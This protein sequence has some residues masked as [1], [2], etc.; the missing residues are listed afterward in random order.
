MRPLRSADITLF[1]EDGANLR[2]AGANGLTQRLLE[3]AIQELRKELPFA[4]S[5]V[6]VGVGA[7][8]DVQVRSKFARADNYRAF[9]LRDRDFLRRALVEKNRTQVFHRKPDQVLPWPLPRHCI[10]SYLLDTDVLGAVAPKIDVAVIRSA[11]DQAASARKWND[12]AHGALDDCMFKLRQ[13]RQAMA[14][15]VAD[16]ESAVR[17]ICD[18]AARLRVLYA[19]PFVEDQLVA[20]LDALEADMTSDGPLRHRVD[21]R[22]LV[23]D[24]ER[25]LLAAHAVDLPMGELISALDRQAQAHPPK[26]LL[27]DIRAALE[28]APLEWRTM[29]G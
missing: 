20:E 5:V 19:A 28:Q 26:A 13:V 11:V 4:A 3:A 10:Q 2:K 12:A 21:G 9:G 29:D 1:C 22:E 16:R 6:P 7:K 14:G 8:N 24:V 17:T 27:A 15:N 25:A 18:E 23:K